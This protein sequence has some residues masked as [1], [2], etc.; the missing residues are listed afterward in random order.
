MTYSPEHY[1]K[2]G[3]EDIGY[4]SPDLSSSD[5]YPEYIENEVRESVKEI[6]SRQNENTIT[7]AFMTDIHYNNF[8]N[9]DVRLKRTVNA[10]REIAKRVHIDRLLLGGDFTNEGCREYKSDCF[11]E[12]RAIYSGTDYLPVNGNHDDGTIWD[13]SYIENP[14][15]E[16][17]LTHR[18]MYT[19]F[20]NHLPSLGAKMGEE[21]ALYYYIDDKHT[22]TRYIGLD[23]GDIPYIFENGK[24]K[25]GGQHNFAM[26]QRQ[27]D[28]LCSKALFFEEE[29]WSIV[30]FIHSVHVP[31]GSFDHHLSELKNL[32]LLNNIVSCYKLGENIDEYAGE[33]EFKV[34]AKADFSEGIRGDI[35]GIFTGD[36]HTDRIAKDRAGNP[37]VLTGNAVMYCTKNPCYV[38]RYDGDKSELLFDVITIDKKLRKIFITRVGAGEDRETEY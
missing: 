9:H 18:D 8:Y 25:H 17:N 6:Q 37:Y 35:M 27:I 34:H 11:R 7:F 3:Y 1:K 30:I 26:S 21:D 19:L 31:D 10:Y 36:Y 32:T 12:L 5:I 4:K 33:N 13:D 28:W 29:G 20:Y 15:S 2:T 22:K 23:S 38:Q 24:L 16:N 14:L